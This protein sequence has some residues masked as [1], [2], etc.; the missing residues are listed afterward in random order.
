MAHPIFERPIAHRGLHDSG[1]GI[2]ENSRAAFE[3]A[4]T[5]GFGI[6]CDLQLTE[7]GE[8]VVFHDADLKRLTGKEGRVNATSAE[9]LC[10]MP[11]LGSADGNTPIRF[12]ELLEGINGQVPLIVEIKQQEYP[13]QTRNLAIRALTDAANYTG[14]IAFKSFDPVALHTLYGSGYRGPLGIITYDYSVEA[15][16][17][18]GVQKFLLRNVLHRKISR[19]NFISCERT[20]LTRGMIRFNRLFGMKVMSWT[21]RSAEEARMALKHA[22]QIVFEGFDPEK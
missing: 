18:N 19:F 14:P 4:I 1:K 15:D 22:D 9:A 2:V 7:D 13:D 20:A 11:L 10:S 3:A 8:A 6:E 12:P 21:V 5:R 16:H 17:L